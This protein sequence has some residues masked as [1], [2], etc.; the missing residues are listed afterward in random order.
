MDIFESHGLIYHISHVYARLQFYFYGREDKW[1]IEAFRTWIPMALFI[2]VKYIFIF[3][4]KFGELS[5]LLQ[6]FLCSWLPKVRVK[7]HPT[8]SSILCIN[9]T[10]SHNFIPVIPSLFVIA[11][12]LKVFFN[13]LLCPLHPNCYKSHRKQCDI[14][15][16]DMSFWFASLCSFSLSFPF[17]SCSYLYS[18]PTKIAFFTL[19]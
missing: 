14:S 19:S 2:Q 10:S 1:G 9:Q 15:L 11:K 16:F 12:R 6:S 5:V 4:S 3:G 13:F 17:F 7:Y 8:C 18:S